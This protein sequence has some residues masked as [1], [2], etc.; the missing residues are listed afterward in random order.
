MLPLPPLNWL[1]CWACWS[2]EPPAA[3]SAAAA[4]FSLPAAFGELPAAATA[5]DDGR[6]PAGVTMQSV[7]WTA[8]MRNSLKVLPYVLV[9]CWPAATRVINRDIMCTCG[10]ASAALPRAELCRVSSVKRSGTDV[11]V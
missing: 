1:G 9:F 7:R 11:P 6:R 8:I 2:G 5:I 4:V 3:A 10:M